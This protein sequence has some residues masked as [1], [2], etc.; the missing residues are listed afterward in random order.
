MTPQVTSIREA[1]T[2]LCLLAV[3]ASFVFAY[4]SDGGS[5]FFRA[6]IWLCEKGSAPAGRLMA[7]FYAGLCGVLGAIALLSGL[8]IV[9]A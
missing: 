8:G 4:Y 9:K 1:F 2:G 6:L 7:F 3:G 5:R